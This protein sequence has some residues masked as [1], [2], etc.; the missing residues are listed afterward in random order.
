MKWLMDEF[1]KDQG[2]DVSSDKMVIQRLREAAE[3]KIELSSVQETEVNLPFLTAD[4]TRPQAP[5]DQTVPCKAGGDDRA[6][7]GADH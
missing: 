4:A 5:P 1:K 2:I 6:I 3:S 7:G